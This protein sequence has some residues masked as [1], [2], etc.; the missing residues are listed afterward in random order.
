MFQRAQY[1]FWARQGCFQHVEKV[2]EH[3]TQSRALTFF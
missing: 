1:C 2:L 3:E